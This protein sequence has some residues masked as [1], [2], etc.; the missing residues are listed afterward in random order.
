MN[1]IFQAFCCRIQQFESYIQ[2][3]EH[4]KY[5]NIAVMNI[6]DNTNYA[7]CGSRKVQLEWQ[8]LQT[9]VAEA[10]QSRTTLF[11]WAYL[12]QILEMLPENLE[13]VLI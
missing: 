10:V 12:S 7:F 6:K 9:L 4:Q 13:I 3:I 8:K 11:T 5:C 2:C 1:I